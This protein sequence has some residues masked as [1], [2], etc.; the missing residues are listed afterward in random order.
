MTK[1]TPVRRWRVGELASATGLTVRALHHYEQIGLLKPAGRTSS[2]H[3]LYDERDVERLYH[4][5]TL[6]DLGVSLAEIRRTIDGEGGA[7]VEVLREHL[8]RANRELE[9]LTRIR[10]RLQRVCAHVDAPVDVDA[11]LSAI[12]AMSRVERHVERRR[13]E[14]RAPGG[15]EARWRELGDALRAS[16][17]AGDEPSSPRAQA[18]ARRLKSRLLDFAGDDPGM[19]DALALLRRASPP[20]DLAGWDPPLFRYLDRALESLAA[21]NEEETGPC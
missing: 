9:R 16:M 6:R 10:D 11:L 17:D 8:A 5:L 2:H 4:V 18:I 20:R 3:R 15:E 12:E 19:M 1:E 21:L 7:L 13:A 14:G